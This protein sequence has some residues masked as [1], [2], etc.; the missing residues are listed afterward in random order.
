MM[1]WIA[2]PG[3]AEDRLNQWLTRKNVTL[4]FLGLSVFYSALLAW[5]A[6]GLLKPDW[7]YLSVVPLAYGLGAVGTA[8]ALWKIDRPS[9]ATWAIAYFFGALPAI[10][11][12][13]DSGV[14]GEIAGLLS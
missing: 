14:V 1:G 3:S 13:L 8:V 2:K 10:K 11:M 9:T 6:V 5:A 12:L 7:R 4:T